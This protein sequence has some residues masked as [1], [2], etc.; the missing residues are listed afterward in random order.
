MRFSLSCLVA[1]ISAHLAL[2][3]ARA[4]GDAAAELFRRAIANETTAPNFV[5]ISLVT[6]GDRTKRMVAIPAPFLLGA[7]HSEY[8][9]AYDWK[10]ET[11]AKEIALGRPER[12]FEFRNPAALKNVQPSYSEA[13]LAKARERLG[14]IGDA[15]ILVGFRGGT[16]RLHNLYNDLP[17]RESTAMRDAIAHVLIERGFLVGHGCVAGYITVSR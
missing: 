15:A 3:E 11:R 4:S 2:H 12:A 14:K 5:L 8:H 16:G 13:D 1:L 17:D 9:L 10:G 6:D 7:I